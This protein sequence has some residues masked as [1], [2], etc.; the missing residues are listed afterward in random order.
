M[1][2]WYHNEFINQ[3]SERTTFEGNGGYN[4]L[5]DQLEV[6]LNVDEATPAEPKKVTVLYD[7]SNSLII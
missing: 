5:S 6:K 7:Y 1:L 4:T 2:T 3:P